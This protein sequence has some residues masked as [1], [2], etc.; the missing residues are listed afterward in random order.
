M[1]YN[2]RELVSKIHSMSGNPYIDFWD[3]LK[4]HISAETL[5]AEHQTTATLVNMIAAEID[6]DPVAVRRLIER[7]RKR[8]VPPESIADLIAILEVLGHK[9]VVVPN[10][11]VNYYYGMQQEILMW[12]NRALAAEELTRS[13]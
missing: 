2:A 1:S 12:K 9:L 3:T 5:S 8:G 6:G 10:R 4:A 11:E 7:W 13:Q